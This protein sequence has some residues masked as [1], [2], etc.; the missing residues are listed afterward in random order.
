M[1]Y[2]KTTIEA[3]KTIEVY[4]SYTKSTGVK[5]RSG[6]EHITPEEMEKINQANAERNLRILINANFKEG[7]LF[8]TLT[9]RKED[10]QIPA[11]AKKSVKA[12]LDTLRLDYKKYGEDLKYIN[13]T[14]YKN[15]AIHHHLILNDIGGL[16]VAKRIRQLWKYG[17]PDF[18]LLD[19]TGQYKDLAAYLIKETSK[20]F[21]EQDGGHMQRYSCSRNLIRP[22]PKMEI[23]RKASRWAAD[24][25]PIKGYY[26][27]QDTIINKINPFTGREYQR[28]TMIQ[29]DNDSGG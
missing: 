13:V 4:K 9:Y 11:E 16:K 5:D 14:E 19:D 3:G 26:I 20:T 17:R 23:V 10:R 21:K 24:P 28:Y 12:F 8:I 1:A 22:L 6:K 2:F 7:D 25:K 29:I 27:D 18:K 15:T